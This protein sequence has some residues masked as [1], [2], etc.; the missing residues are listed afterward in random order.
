MGE[1]LGFKE[2]AIKCSIPLEGIK[3]IEKTEKKLKMTLTQGRI[4]EALAET[5]DQTDTKKVTTKIKDATNIKEDT[6]GIKNIEDITNGSNGSKHDIRVITFNMLSQNAATS[7]YFPYVKDHFLCFTFRIVRMK[8]LLSS[9]MKVNFIICLQEFS[10][11]W[12]SVLKGFFEQNSYKIFYRLYAKDKMGVAI[13]YPTKHYDLINAVETTLG[14][15]IKM[16][17]QT[18]KYNNQTCNAQIDPIKL[19]VVMRELEFAENTKNAL[20]SIILRPKYHGTDTGRNLVV[21]TYHMPCKFTQKYYMIAQILAL[22]ISLEKLLAS[23]KTYVPGKTSVVM[24][25]DFNISPINPEYKLLA[26]VPYTEEELK[27]PS[28]ESIAT[29]KNIYGSIGVDLE[30]GIKLHSAHVTING[31]EPTYTNVSIKVGATFIDCIDY[32]LIG[33]SVEIRSCKAGLTTTHPTDT[34]Y[35]NA[36]CP[37]DHIPLSASLRI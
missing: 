4:I 34:G 11:G 33:E 8:K 27:I 20:L 25:G 37:S 9:W 22:K 12:A 28:Y 23:T 24:T 15:E 13:A 36:I 35:P 31:K 6:T 14:P 30:Q 16:I 26:G 21:S 18:L 29:M 5:T 10:K 17:N 3:K 32:I 19:S 1:I 7:E 2:L